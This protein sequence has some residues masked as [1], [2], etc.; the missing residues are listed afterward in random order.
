MDSSVLIKAFLNRWY[1]VLL[2]LLV[3]MLRSS[4]LRGYFG[5]FIVNVPTRLF[6][7]KD[8]FHLAKNATL[9][10]EDGTTQTSYIITFHSR[11]LVEE[12][13]KIS[14]WV[15]AMTKSAIGLS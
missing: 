9:P 8:R 6:L 7:D 5:K 2:T 11:V 4:W 15:F 12:T 1:F 14:S 13:K 3:A 10:T